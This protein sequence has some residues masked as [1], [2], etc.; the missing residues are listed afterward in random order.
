MSGQWRRSSGLKSD[1]EEPPM[2]SDG[3]G[4][5]GCD[6]GSG[7]ALLH[8]HTHV[9][10][11]AHDIH[12]SF[13]WCLFEE[14]GNGDM[15]GKV[16]V[17]SV[18]ARGLM[19]PLLTHLR[20]A[21]EGVVDAVDC[22]VL[23]SKD[24]CM[25][26]WVALGL[27][28]SVASTL[29]E[30]QLRLVEGRIQVSSVAMQSAT[31]IEA[32]SAALV[33]VWRFKAFTASRWLTIGT[34]CRTLVASQLS[35][36][37]AVVDFLSSRGM[38][39]TYEVQGY[40]AMDASCWV[41]AA[42]AC[43]LSRLPE[44]LLLMVFADNRVARNQHEFVEAMWNEH[45]TLVSLPVSVIQSVSA[46]IGVEVHAFRNKLYR[47]S[48][49]QLAFLHHRLIDQLQSLPWNEFDASD[50]VVRS[51]VALAAAGFPRAKLEEGVKLL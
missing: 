1:A 46:L 7:D 43:F 3:G 30:F 26:I 48:L 12:N 37:S 14:H 29:A 16:H 4:G 27:D 40:R 32:L 25:S 23:P 39:P 38:L 22:C 13:K 10:C 9:G 15:L 47:G 19:V 5:S 51:I 33:E 35:G 50:P 42:V 44:T 18:A 11:C 2:S 41:F 8:W 21:L 28:E 6:A 24:A 45:E 36:F 17:G 20:V 34:C 49:V 31:A